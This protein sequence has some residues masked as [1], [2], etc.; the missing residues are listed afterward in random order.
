[1][2]I[3]IK[4]EPIN[5]FVTSVTFAIHPV[6][7]YFSSMRF[8][9]YLC[10]LLVNFDPFPSNVSPNWNPMNIADG[11][12]CHASD[13]AGTMQMQFSG[14]LADESIVLEDSLIDER[15]CS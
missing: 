12:Q 2:Y 8:S 9:L 10:F 1:M 5:S 6:E 11:Y 15:W 4:V 3:H 7:C 13:V 14:G